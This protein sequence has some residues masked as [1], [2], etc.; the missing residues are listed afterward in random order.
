MKKIK[1][2]KR[3]HDK[4]PWYER[5][6]LLFSAIAILLAGAGLLMAHLNRNVGS[7]SDPVLGT[8]NQAD[9]TQVPQAGEVSGPG[10]WHLAAP[11]VLDA[12][13]AIP[14]AASGEVLPPIYAETLVEAAHV[15][16]NLRRARD[17]QPWSSGAEAAYGCLPAD[18]LVA[19]ATG[20]ALG[21][22]IG[23]ELTPGS[24][25]RSCCD[26]E[27]QRDGE[28]KLYLMAF[29][30][31][32]TAEA[33]GK[34]GPRMDLAPEPE[35]PEPPRWQFWKKRAAPE[36]FELRHGSRIVLYPDLSPEGT[37]AVV[38]PLDR[39]QFSAGRRVR[40]GLGRPVEVL[41][42]SLL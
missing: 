13:G 33:F 16:E 39:L 17:L 4:V 20:E 6:V 36:E 28:G 11:H 21:S 18:S 5:P 34:A 19:A 27:I 42:A 2:T 37:C 30:G 7:N 23:G 22:E 12:G 14:Q 26:F 1:V 24:E 41:E 8:S 10:G 25:C 40:E 35:G 38:L 9:S 31:L 32:E 29:V 15:R 3:V